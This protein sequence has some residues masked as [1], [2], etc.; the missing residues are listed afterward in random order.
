M[1]TLTQA[2]KT[3][4][5]KHKD[6]DKNFATSKTIFVTSEKTIYRISSRNNSIIPLKPK[7]VVY[8]EAG[9]IYQIVSKQALEYAE[10]YGYEEC[11]NIYQLEINKKYVVEKK[12]FEFDENKEYKALGEYKFP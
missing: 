2:N 11:K 3:L 12:L 6:L 8:S 9:N 4:V 7:N 5:E 1:V 10:E